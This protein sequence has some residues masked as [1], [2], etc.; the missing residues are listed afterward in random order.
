MDRQV[1]NLGLLKSSLLYFE[2]NSVPLHS[3]LIFLSSFVCLFRFIFLIFIPINS[4]SH[5]I[6]ILYIHPLYISY[7]IDHQLVN[8][9]LGSSPFIIVDRL[10]TTPSLTVGYSHPSCVQSLLRMLSIKVLFNLPLYI[11]SGVSIISLLQK[12]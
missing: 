3:F 5:I 7:A 8:L 6:L 2:K 4:P 12:I 9:I 1:F 11:S 10:Q